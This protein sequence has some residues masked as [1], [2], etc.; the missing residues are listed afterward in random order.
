M[1]NLHQ[2]AREEGV[3]LPLVHQLREM[4]DIAQDVM[5]TMFGTSRK[6]IIIARSVVIT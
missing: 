6:V 2:F 4:R 5:V 3:L 1:T